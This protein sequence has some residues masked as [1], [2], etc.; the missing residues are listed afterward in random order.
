L[1][2]RGQNLLGGFAVLHH[3]IWSAPEFRFW[4]HK[5]LQSV[6]GFSNR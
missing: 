6:Y 1:I 2:G 4:G 3:G 5:L